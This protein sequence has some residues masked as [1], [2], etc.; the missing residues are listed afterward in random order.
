[1]KNQL[2]VVG[3][4][5]S[6]AKHSSSLAA[7]RIALEGA[8]EAGA[9]TEL[10]DIRDLALPTYDPDNN[11]PPN[12]VRHLCESIYGANGLIWS[13]PMYHGTISGSFKNA[14]DWLQLLGDR[15]PPYLTDKVVGLISTAGGV[16]GLQAVNTLE[17]VVRALR[18]WAVPLVMPIAQAW[19]AF[20]DQGRAQDPLLADQLH[21]LGKEVARGSCQFAL[22]PPTESDASKAEAEVTPASDREAR[23]A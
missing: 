2:V 1:M 3:L 19:K 6:L 22:E 4:G 7:L 5:G 21:A 20:D 14:L 17:F 16:Q 15:K 9:R 18:G 8:A 12:S 23:S 13:S 11:D 10:L